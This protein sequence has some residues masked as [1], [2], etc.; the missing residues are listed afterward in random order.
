MK[1]N[2]ESVAFNVVISGED[3]LGEEK[4]GASFERYS[5]KANP[6]DQEGKG[7]AK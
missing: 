4:L 6:Q 1:I 5:G 2:G 7:G 3:N